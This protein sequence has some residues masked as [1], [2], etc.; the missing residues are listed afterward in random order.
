MEM[1][2]DDVQVDGRRLDAGV[3]EK[4]LNCPELCS[5]LYQG[6]GKEVTQAVRR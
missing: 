1:L 6:G 4:F 2:R 5:L 3:A